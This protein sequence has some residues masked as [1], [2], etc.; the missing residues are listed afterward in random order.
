MKIS[1]LHMGCVE[2]DGKEYPIHRARP[3]YLYPIPI[4]DSGILANKIIKLDN[5]WNCKICGFRAIQKKAVEF[6]EIS[7]FAKLDPELELETRQI[8]PGFVVNTKKD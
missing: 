5:D 8:K 1:E 6:E 7:V 4:N 3:G 2:M